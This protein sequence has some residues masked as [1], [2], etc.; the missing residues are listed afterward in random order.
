MEKGRIMYLGKKL[1][2]SN[3]VE[4]KYV[5]INDNNKWGTYWKFKVALFKKGSI[6]S[7]Y[8]CKFKGSKVSYNKNIMP[9]SFIENEKDVSISTFIF[10]PKLKIEEEETRQA[11]ILIR[12]AKKQ[13][14]LVNLEIDQIREVYKRLTPQKRSG[15]IGN[16][17]YQITK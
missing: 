12:N 16:L 17:I 11:E 2:A 3:C 8:E 7:I 9:T 1:D 10:Y 15:F 13:P 6:G 5:K 4:H 14:S